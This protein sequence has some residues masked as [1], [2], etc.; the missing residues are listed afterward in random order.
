MANTDAPGGSSDFQQELLA[1][2]QDPQVIRFA[3]RLAGDLDLAEDLLQTAYCKLAALKH[4]ERIENLRGYYL[5]VL[6]NE[7][8]Q[9]PHTS[10][11]ET[12]RIPRTAASDPGSGPAESTTR[13]ATSLLAPHLAPA[14]RRPARA[15]PGCDSGSLG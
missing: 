12:S 5:R 8:T 4:P 7:A 10:R 14:P 1:I 15:P 6:Q 9:A 2:R 13:F 11:Q 3:R